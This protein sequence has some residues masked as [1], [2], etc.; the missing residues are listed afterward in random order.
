[1][2]IREV[3]V[4]LVTS[5]QGDDEIDG[6]ASRMLNDAQGSALEEE[7]EENEWEGDEPESQEY[8]PMPMTA[9]VPVGGTGIDWD[10]LKT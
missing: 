3:V 7:E 4:A 6:G 1:M 2:N 10:L 9:G 5:L 8:L